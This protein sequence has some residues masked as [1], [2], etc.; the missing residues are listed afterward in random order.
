MKT[1]SFAYHFSLYR[2]L[3]IEKRYIINNLSA[4]TSDMTLNSNVQ[5]SESGFA[6][7]SDVGPARRASDLAE[8]GEETTVWQN[9]GGNGFTYDFDDDDEDYDATTANDSIIKVAN[10]VKVTLSKLCIV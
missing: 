4:T 10:S 8:I 1:L 3:L 6:I 7:Y 5:H 9:R 2:K